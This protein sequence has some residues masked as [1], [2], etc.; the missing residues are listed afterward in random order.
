MT[1]APPGTRLPGLDAL[2]GL[3]IVGVVAIHAA[4]SGESLYTEHV[5]G[6]VTR[7][8]VPLFLVVSGFL[9][10]SR[11]PSRAKASRYFWKFLRLHLLYGALYWVVQPPLVGTAYAPVTPKSALM[12]FA[13]FSYAGQFYLF[14]LTQIYFA[15]AFLLPE[16]LWSRATLLLA[17]AALH[18]A[19]VA[20]LGWSFGDPGAGPLTRLLVGQAEATAFLWLLPFCLGVW[21]GARVA[22]APEAFSGPAASALFAALAVILVTL[23]LPPT[24]G[25]SYAQRFPY[26]RWSIAIGAALLALAVPCASRHLRLGPVAALGRE[27]FGIFVLN[28]LILGVLRRAF[29][30]V[31]SVPESALYA[32]VTLAIAFL[33]ARALR[34]RI[35]FAFP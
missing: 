4:P 33:L 23:D 14:A 26:A 22:R 5:I 9:L 15:F 7:L 3:A 31:E 13:A 32:A 21:L 20:A 12:H 19:T 1:A 8:A 34:P 6:G 16:K 24:D 17:S 35:P 29:G 28:T 27:S 2:K 30:G 18:A 10:G 11:P 25:V